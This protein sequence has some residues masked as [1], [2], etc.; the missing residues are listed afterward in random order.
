MGKRNEILETAPEIEADCEQ[1]ANGLAEVQ[2]CADPLNVSNQEADCEQDDTIYDFSNENEEVEDVCEEQE[3]AITAEETPAENDEEQV[4]YEIE[5][6]D[7]ETEDFDDDEEF[8]ETVKEQT[9]SPE[10]ARQKEEELDKDIERAENRLLEIEPIYIL[11]ESGGL[12]KL[13]EQIKQNLYKNVDDTEMK[14]LKSSAKNMEDVIAVEK[15]ITNFVSECQNLKRSIE[16]YKEQKQELRNIQLNMFKG[17][18][19]PKQEENTKPVVDEN[20]TEKAET[21]NSE[22]T[23]TVTEDSGLTRHP[24]SEDERIEE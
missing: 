1:R 20:T 22:E 11:S 4:T 9:M 5:C 12:F 16:R 8:M 3:N 23:N 19:L 6:E 10:K 21:A 15:L 24:Q 18:D 17:A 2:D 7:E 13:K 14:E